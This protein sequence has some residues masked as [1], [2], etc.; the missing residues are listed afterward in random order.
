M[1]KQTEDTQTEAQTTVPVPGLT[2]EELKRIY[3]HLH[4]DAFA[5]ATVWWVE[6][7]DGIVQEM[8]VL[9][10]RPKAGAHW[11]RWPVGS[12]SLY[13]EPPPAVPGHEETTV[14]DTMT[15]SS[16]DAPCACL[17][18]PEWVAGLVRPGD[19]YRIYQ[20]AGDSVQGMPHTIHYAITRRAALQLV[21]GPSDRSTY[22]QRIWTA[23]AKIA[24]NEPM[25]G[26]PTLDW[27]RQPTESAF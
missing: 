3:Q 9:C 4:P 16:H 12:Q 10:L 11:V 25:L 1:T 23:L 15:C 2:A 17:L 20:R 8:P 6:P 18:V 5:H 21:Y 22:M 26:G 27:L 19:A 24:Q 13:V 7:M 14:A